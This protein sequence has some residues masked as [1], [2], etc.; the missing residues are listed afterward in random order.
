MHMIQYNV[1][2]TFMYGDLDKEIL[3]KQLE[4]YK[5]DV[6]LVCRFKQ[7]IY[8]LKQSTRQWN[9]TF[10]SFLIRCNLVASNVDLYVYH[11]MDMLR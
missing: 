1:C 5:K 7:N 9:H 2:I 6:I 10:D 8:N 4:G 3:I 11:K